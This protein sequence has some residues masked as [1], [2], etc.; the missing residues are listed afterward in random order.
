ML[1]PQA[2]LG[3]G[4]HPVHA[5]MA[6]QPVFLL[7]ATQG[8]CTAYDPPDFVPN[9]AAS[10]L[11]QAEVLRLKSGACIAT[12]LHCICLVDKQSSLSEV[13][14]APFTC[15]NLMGS[16]FSVNWTRIGSL[17]CCSS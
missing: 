17:L 13:K 2:V 14:T 9:S 5:L 12:V 3:R 8:G 16:I 10:V 6:K 7:G 15:D 1:V 11:V 4:H